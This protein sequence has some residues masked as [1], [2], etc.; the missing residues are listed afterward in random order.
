MSRSWTHKKVSWCDRPKTLR[1]KEVYRHSVVKEERMEEWTGLGRIG[2]PESTSSVE[3]SM[4]K[5]LRR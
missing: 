2:S 3:E 5:R 4:W 1:C